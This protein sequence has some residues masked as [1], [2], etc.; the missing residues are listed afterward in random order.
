MNAQFRL[1]FFQVPY[2][3]SQNDYERSS[4]YYCS[5]GLRNGQSESDSFVI[6]N[7]IHTFSPK[8]KLLDDSIT[9]GG[10]Q[11]Q[12]SQHVFCG[13]ALPVPFLMSVL[14]F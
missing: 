2:D 14:G 3:P 11:L 1:D 10:F 9:V 13:I 8:A 7:W 5:S 6:A 4:D 12:R